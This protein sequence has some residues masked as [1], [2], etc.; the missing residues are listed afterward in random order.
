[1]KT[2]RVMNARGPGPGGKTNI[3][4]WLATDVVMIDNLYWHKSGSV[5]PPLTLGKLASRILS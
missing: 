5:T 2:T 3:P 1:M 4:G